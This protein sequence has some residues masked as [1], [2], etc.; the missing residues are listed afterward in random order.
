VVAF[1]GVGA[2][3]DKFSDIG[4][5]DLLP[6]G[7]GGLR[8]RLLKKYPVNFRIDYGQGKDGH[9]LSIGVMEAF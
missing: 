4:A 9:T 6:G 3:A 1:F 7:G 8:F 5:G 2:V